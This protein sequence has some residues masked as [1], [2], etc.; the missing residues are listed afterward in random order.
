MI[1]PSVNQKFAIPI[2]ACR[3]NRDS[4]GNFVPA[5]VRDSYDRIVKAEGVIE[6][7]DEMPSGSSISPM[8]EN[9]L[10]HHCGTKVNV[11]QLIPECWGGS[12]GHPDNY[13]LPTPKQ[14]K[15]FCLFYPFDLR[16]KLFFNLAHSCH[17]LFF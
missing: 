8:M 15:I 14:V 16:V 3:S 10:R 13:I 4:S 7:K 5:V 2:T 1:S 6:V 9:I 12:G 17:S 11:Y